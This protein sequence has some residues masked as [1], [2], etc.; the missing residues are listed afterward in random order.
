MEGN[1]YIYKPK[2]QTKMRSLIALFI[3]LGFTLSM[4]AQEVPVDDKSG[5]IT[6][7][8]VVD[9]AGTKDELFERLNKWFNTFYKNP[10]GVIQSSDATAGMVVGKHRFYSEIVTFDKKGREAGRT[11]GGSIQYIITVSCKDGKFRYHITDVILL[12]A[13]KVAAETWIGDG[14]AT[15]QEYLKQIDAFMQDLIKNLTGAMAPTVGEDNGE[16]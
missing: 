15:N 6:Y 13:P 10:K 9:Q 11:R 4:Q 14:N 2:K 7:V 12:K 5:K 1:H 16:W 3:L 8:K